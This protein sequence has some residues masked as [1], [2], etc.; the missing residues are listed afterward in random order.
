MLRGGWLPVCGDRA[1]GGV[2]VYGLASGQQV[3]W[4]AAAQC[5]VA[6]LLVVEQQGVLPP[7]LPHRHSIRAACMCFLEKLVCHLL[8]NE[9]GVLSPAA[10][11]AA[12]AQALSRQCGCG[13]GEACFGSGQ[14]CP[15]QRHTRYSPPCWMLSIVVAAIKRWVRP[16]TAL[17]GP[18]FCL[19]CLG[20]DPE[21]QQQQEQQ[22]THPG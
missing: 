10:A 2:C 9:R 1:A 4:E 11:H 8:V 18:L 19:L 13:T 16:L 3:F 14:P 15:V 20:R 17:P 21:C 6:L 12:A 7:Q 5:V 22:H